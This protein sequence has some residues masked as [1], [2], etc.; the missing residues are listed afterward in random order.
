V[1]ALKINAILI[2]NRGEIAVRI[3]G[4]CRRL[5]IRAVAAY[6]TADRYA[7]HVALAD[8]AVLIGPA[9][10]AQS[11]LNAEAI[12]AAARRAGVDAIHPGYGF[13][14]ESE[15][16]IAACEHAEI[17]FIGPHREAIRRMGSKIESKTLAEQAGVPTIPGYHGLDQSESA[18]LGA[19]E[20]IGFPLMI[21]ASAGGGGRGMRRIDRAEQL[22]AL[23][24]QARQEALSAF[25]DDQ[26]LLEKLITSPRHIEVQLA[27]DKHGHIVHL[28]E[29]ECSIQRNHQKVIE[30]APAA[31]LDEAQRTRL[32]R[33]AITLGQAITYDSLGTV[34]F[35]L[36]NTTGK[37]YFLEMNTRLQV[38]HPVT[39]AI[40]G[41]DLVEWQIRIASGEP[42]PLTQ[43]QINATGW[44]IE[45]RVNAEDPAHGYR[46]E[47][48]TIALYREPSGDDVRVDSGI[49]H[50]SVIT[51]YYDPMLAKII[52]RGADR[53]QARRAL[54]RGLRDYTLAGVGSNLGFLHDVVA[55]SNFA[56]RAL[57]TNYLNESFVDG[58]HK[59]GS[60]VTMLVCAA[61]AKVMLFEQARSDR[62]VSPWQS[63]GGFRLLKQAGFPGQ[64]RIILATS[65]GD[66]EVVTVSGLN[67][68]YEASIAD[69]EAKPLVVQAQWQ[70]SGQ[71]QIEIDGVSRRLQVDYIDEEILLR[72]TDGNFRYRT[73][74]EQEL[75]LREKDG[76]GSGKCHAVATLPGQVV[77][78]N[79]KLGDKVSKGDVLVVLDS[80]KLLHELTAQID[81]MVAAVFC[82]VSDSVDGGAMLI[83]LTPDSP[84]NDN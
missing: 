48:G 83:E 32:Y 51:P 78:I 35:L 37:T 82:E 31:F 20:T 45:A 72:S 60:S 41:L 24:P 25:G 46:P 3:I 2:A 10:S 15:A 58:W 63:L 76:K 71:L 22:V 68:V 75:A 18:L 4:T 81:G 29:R 6:S 84:T 17:V 5:G 61:I 49:S 62:H 77:E 64:S 70:D 74:D 43:D 40:T 21:K 26:V 34:E 30:E 44:A 39:E 28:F 54:L 23:L 65:E 12:I 59:P 52:G 66:N 9:E 16:L 67:G 1:S 38:E 7:P 73:L 27:A 79:V 19:A 42:L 80:M 11:Y 55:H 53:E 14:S 13:L 36:D 69:P 8:E 50:G 56:G 47:T 57:S 33:D